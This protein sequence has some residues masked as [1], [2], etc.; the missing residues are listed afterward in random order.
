MKFGKWKTSMATTL[1]MAAMLSAV[2]AA[3]IIAPP[4]SIPTDGQIMAVGLQL[5]SPLDGIHWDEL[6][7]N[8]DPSSLQSITVKNTG[9]TTLNVTYI[10]SGWSTNIDH[11]LW[12]DINGTLLEP[13]FELTAHFT[14]QLLGYP[15]PFATTFTFNIIAVGTSL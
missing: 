9:I 1:I 4:V 15:S 13:G 11:Y 5:V 6:Q 8:G 2:I 7:V 14:L 10:E 12:S 3:P